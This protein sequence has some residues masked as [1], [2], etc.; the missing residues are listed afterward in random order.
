MVYLIVKTNTFIRGVIILNSAFIIKIAV[1]L[2]FNLP[3]II[4]IL[5]ILTFVVSAITSKGFE[6]EHQL[7]KLISG[8]MGVLSVIITS[9]ILNFLPKGGAGI[10]GIMDSVG[11]TV[12]KV[13][14]IA[15]MLLVISQTYEEKSKGIKSLIIYVFILIP[16]VFLM[17]KV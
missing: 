13:L 15:F 7:D 3:L 10:L 6:I 4:S 1:T 16:F 9:I 14:N 12:I 11:Y 2:F 17:N 5:L 8:G